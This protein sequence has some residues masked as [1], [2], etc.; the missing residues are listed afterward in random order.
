[1]SEGCSLEMQ[2]RPRLTVS[3]VYLSPAPSIPI[4]DMIHLSYHGAEPLVCFSW[5][6]SGPVHLNTVT[7]KRSSRTKPQSPQ[8]RV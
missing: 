7:A 8:F 5:V 2:N 4:A 6:P 3:D 1:M